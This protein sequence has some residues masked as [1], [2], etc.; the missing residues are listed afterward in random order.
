MPGHG[1]TAQDALAASVTRA[2]SLQ[3]YLTVRW[4]ADPAFRA[5]GYGLYAY[6]RWLD[7]QVDE[8]LPDEP[9]RLAFV[10]Q[11]RAVLAAAVDGRPGG[12]LRP[13]ETLLVGLVDRDRARRP[14]RPAGGAPDDEGLLLCLRS[15]LDVMQVDAGR[16]GRAVDAATL[17]A[18]T[19]S[20]SVAVTEALHHCIGHGAGAPHGADRYVAVRGAHVAHMLRD[21]V[22]DVEAGYLNLPAQLVRHDA[23]PSEWVHEPDVRAWVRDRVALARSC[24]AAGRRSFAAV[25][26]RRCRLAGHAY[27][28]RFEW[29]LDTIEREGFRLRP[30][31]PE[32]ATWRGGVR[33]AVGTARS[34]LGGSRNRAPA[35]R[36]AVGA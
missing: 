17:D 1:G 8:H 12:V 24:F 23:R 26:S 16:R 36:Q 31:Y 21:L 10:A 2:A 22:E 19:Q 3:S 28:A 6:F 27:V 9:A 34:A 4:L 11:Q 32:R 15:M 33:I 14:Q 35:A 13:E 30:S 5:D 29:V 25:E 7:D 18:Y 20:L